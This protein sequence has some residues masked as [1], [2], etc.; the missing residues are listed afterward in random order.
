MD[1]KGTLSKRRNSKT[2][3]SRRGHDKESRTRRGQSN[4]HLLYYN[5]SSSA[6]STRGVRSRFMASPNAADEPD[7]TPVD[8]APV[9][10]GEAFR[11]LAGLE[12]EDEVA[13]VSVF[14]DF[15]DFF[16]LV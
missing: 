15:L 13:S 5:H 4:K 11:D 2:K 16:F 7:A 10:E 3:C 12:A 9:L 8:V 14:L 6:S 1:A